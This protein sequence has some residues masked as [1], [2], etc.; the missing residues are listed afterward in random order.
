MA[1]L[2][3]IGCPE[4]TLRDIILADV[5]QYFEGRRSEVSRQTPFWLAGRQRQDAV[6]TNGLELLRIDQ[7]ERELLGQLLGLEWCGGNVLIQ[8]MNL[9]EQAVMRF[10]FGPVPDETVQQ[11]LFTMHKFE[12]LRDQIGH[13]TGGIFTDEDDAEMKRL[14][15]EL[16]AEIGQ[17]L[18]PMQFEEMK[19]RC[20]AMDLFERQYGV[21]LNAEEARRIAL[22]RAG[23]S[24]GI[25]WDGPDL[26]TE[27]EQQLREARFQ[28]EVAG[29]LGAERFQDYQ[30]SQ[31][32]DFR[33]IFYFTYGN[34]MPKETAI[35]VYDMRRLA[36]EEVSRIQEDSS[37][38]DLERL[39]RMRQ[40]QA[41]VQE[42]VSTVLGPVYQEYLDSSGSWVTNVNGL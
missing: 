28:D 9:A 33:Q 36:A 23:G 34:N 41:S 4:R 12:I 19:A 26:E 3:S 13:R 21:E 2:R 39:E 18:T 37:L 8:E 17:L 6:R 24:A 11:V 30:R 22:A 40:I 31:D 10:V 32:E 7:E 20:A 42:G 16:P 29:I 35:K 25:F 14:Q 15:L 1:N 38:T 27:E 5:R